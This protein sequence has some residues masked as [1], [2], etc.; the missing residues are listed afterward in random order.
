MACYVSSVLCDG[1]WIGA[2]EL[3]LCGQARLCVLWLLPGE[4]KLCL[5]CEPSLFL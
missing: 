1:E 4:Q 5:T 2:S 3:L